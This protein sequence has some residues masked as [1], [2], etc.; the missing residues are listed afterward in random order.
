ME[1]VSKEKFKSD[2]I[3]F[4]EKESGLTI[5]EAKQKIKKDLIIDKYGNTQNERIKAGNVTLFY[6]NNDNYSGGVKN[7]YG[8]GWYIS[9]GGFTGGST[10]K[11]F[12][13][14]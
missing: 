1:K 9:N 12:N 7:G 10:I 5:T 8:K 2:I 3:S 14:L 13:N 11:L 4:F 6:T